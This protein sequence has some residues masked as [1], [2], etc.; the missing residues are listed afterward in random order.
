MKSY[1]ELV[2]YYRE[3]THFD[4]SQ[5][6]PYPSHQ[7]QRLP[8]PPLAKGKMSD[9]QIK[10]PMDFKSLDLCNDTVN[11]IYSRESRRSF[12]GEQISL[13]QLSFLLWATQGI[14]SMRGNNYATMRTVPCGGARHPFET[15]LVVQNVEGLEKGVYHY[16]PLSNEIEF[17]KPLK[18][19]EQIISDSVVGQKWAGKASVVFYWSIVPYR[20]EWRYGEAACIK[21]LVDVGHV[22]QNLYLACEAAH[23]GTCA[24]ISFDFNLCNSLFDLDGEDEYVLYCSPVGTVSPVD[25]SDEIY[26]FVKNEPGAPMSLS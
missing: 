6:S 12:S 10:L 13:L 7:Q 22:C 5:D 15:Y 25:N 9:K 17:I 21:S 3:I 24:I 8:Q 26:A 19:V 23:L 11:L 4:A 14:K 20:A 16:L 1:E 18:N 2:K